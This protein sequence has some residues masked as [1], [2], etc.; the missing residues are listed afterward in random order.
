[1]VFIGSYLAESRIFSKTFPSLIRQSSKFLRK[2]TFYF[3]LI[4]MEKENSFF[5][6]IKF[7]MCSSVEI[8]LNGKLRKKVCR[9]TGFLVQ[10][11]IG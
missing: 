3:F 10:F 9:Y 2:E 4:V 6:I 1:M 11:E 7:K 8:Y 5:S